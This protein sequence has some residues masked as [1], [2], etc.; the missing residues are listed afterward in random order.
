MSSNNVF[1]G[2]GI[3]S[4]CKIIEIS[5]TEITCVI[6][7]MHEDYLPGLPQEVVV[8]GRVLEESVCRGN[9][10]FTYQ[11]AGTPVVNIPG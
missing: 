6:P 8:T 1:I 2:D 5:S 7:R 11:E 10:A 4:L 3:N 9:C